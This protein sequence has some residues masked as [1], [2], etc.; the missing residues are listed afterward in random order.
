[1]ASRRVSQQFQALFSAR[2]LRKFPGGF[3]PAPAISNRTYVYRPSSAALRQIEFVAPDYASDTAQYGSLSEVWNEC[4]KELYRL[5]AIAGKDPKLIN[6]SEGWE[7]TPVELRKGTLHPLTDAFCQLLAPHTNSS[8]M[9][10]VPARHLASLLNIEEVSKFTVTQCRRV[11][12]IAS[13][14][15]YSVEPDPI[16]TNRAWKV[17]RPVAFYLR[18]TD[19]E[20]DT[21]RYPAAMCMLQIGV[22]VKSAETAISNDEIAAIMGRVAGVFNLN[23]VERRRLEAVAALVGITGAELVVVTRIVK[24]LPAAQREKMA[25]L[26]L[27]LASTSGVIS[28]SELRVVRRVYESL[29]LATGEIERSINELRGDDEPITVVRHNVR[30]KGETIPPR[31]PPADSLKLDHAAIAEI[32]KDTREVTEML[33]VAMSAADNA[34]PPVETDS[35]ADQNTV[36]TTEHSPVSIPQDA[37]IPSLQQQYVPLY[38]QLITKRTWAMAEAESMARQHGLMLGGAI[39]AINEW[40]F[41]AHGEQLLVEDSDNLVVETT[42]ILQ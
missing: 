16:V 26:T 9:A 19:E 3:P 21:S 12:R 18:V 41:D 6:S 29:G 10:V 32:V 35:P 25:K 2:Y 22:A 23:D 40:C 17:D 1:V 37:L 39:E 24:G 11:A 31:Q 42:A 14:I 38:E 4:S 15:G 7:A 20:V 33:A 30:D 5:S 8:G 28:S 34:E 13:E 36:S 27:V